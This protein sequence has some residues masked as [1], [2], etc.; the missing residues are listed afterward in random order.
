V[1]SLTSREHAARAVKA[2]RRYERLTAELDQIEQD[3][4]NRVAGSD[5]DML[6]AASI[7]LRNFSP[8]RIK[9]GDRNVC[10]A[11]ATMEALMSEMVAR[12]AGPHNQH[13]GG[14][15]FEL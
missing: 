9:A 2:Y 1:R 10:L 3:A 12:L 13:V 7:D 15:G 5:V 8:Y 14:E 11:I 6:T 4:I